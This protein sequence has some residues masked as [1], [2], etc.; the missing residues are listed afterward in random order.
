MLL[1]PTPPA[2]RRCYLAR[3]VGAEPQAHQLTLLAITRMA[4]N[5]PAMAAATFAA[6]LRRSLTVPERAH[7]LGHDRLS[8]G[9]K[10]MPSAS[11][12]YRLSVNAP[13]SNPAYEWRTRTRAARRQT[14]TSVRWSIEQMPAALRNAAVVGL[15]GTAARSS[16]P[17][18]RPRPTQEFRVD[19]AGL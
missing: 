12:W 15:T 10:Q 14:G 3:G 9:A 8:G 19:L 16:R 18:T 7:R 17:A 2:R 13:L 11:D 1:R 5:D 4:R 6:R